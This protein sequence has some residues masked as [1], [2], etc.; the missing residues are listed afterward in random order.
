MKETKMMLHVSWILVKK[1]QIFWKTPKFVVT[2]AK[3]LKIREGRLYDVF[4]SFETIVK[5]DIENITG[6]IM[7][8]VILRNKSIFTS[9][10]TKHSLD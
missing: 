5:Y 9:H 3:A 7:K 2:K 1:L 8:S 4:L 6:V 10:N